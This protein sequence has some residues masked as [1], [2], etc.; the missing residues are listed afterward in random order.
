M[1]ALS[2]ADAQ[3]TLEPGGQ[4][5]LAARPVRTDLEFVSDLRTYIAELAE[6]SRELGISWLSAGVSTPCKRTT[7]SV[8]MRCE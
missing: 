3:I 8:P 6:V 4:F 5:E 7:S 1:I 2:R